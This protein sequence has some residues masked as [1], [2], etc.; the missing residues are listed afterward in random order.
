M[1]RRAA[2]EA[3]EQGGPQIAPARPNVPLK[4]FIKIGRP[5][6]KVTKQ[7]DPSTGQQS[8]LFQVRYQGVEDRSNDRSISINFQVDY[9]EI[10]DGIEPRHRFMSA[11]EQH[12]EPPDR[13]WQYLL[14]AAEPYETISFKLPSREI[15]KVSTSSARVRW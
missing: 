15:D 6:Y 11:Y 1:A 2:K 5:G 10:V 4:K 12:I 8:L 14:F 9:P 7:R 3:K 13:K